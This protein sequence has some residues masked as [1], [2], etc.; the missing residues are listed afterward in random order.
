MRA[1]RVLVTRPAADAR[2]WVGQLQARGIAALALPLIDIVACPE[3]A[4]QRA[5]QQAQRYSATP[6][7]YRAVMFVSGNAVQYFFTDPGVHLAAPCR[8]W[9]PG[10][11]TAAA[12]QVAGIAADRIDGPP[13]DAVQFDSEAL[14]PQVRA[15]IQP[16]CRV[17]IVRGSQPPSATAA[18]SPPSR[19][20]FSGQGRE[21]LADQ[22]REAG[23]EVDFV[24][25]YRRSP[26]HF[27]PAAQALAQR[28]A[29]DGT[30]WLFSSSEAVANL[31]QSLP[32]TDWTQAQALTTHPRIAAA[33]RRAGFARVREC[34]PSLDDVVASIESAHEL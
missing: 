2:H 29:H 26:P 19:Q 25:V 33:A 13:A 15:Q 4:A 28:A 14:W 30:L 11:G 10:P 27:T 16:G 32:D 24:A 21:W 17:L 12:L 9:S 31:Q 34:R 22:L 6:G 3:P 20:P 23:A 5:L 7:H 8:A 1:V 18:A